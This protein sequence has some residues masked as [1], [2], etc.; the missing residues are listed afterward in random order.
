MGH[1]TNRA[2][3]E[4]GRTGHGIKALATV[5]AAFLVPLIIIVIFV[6]FRLL[7]FMYARIKVDADMDRAA[8]TAAERYIL[9]GTIGDEGSVSSLLDG[10]IRDYPYYSPDDTEM[11]IVH[12]KIEVRASLDTVNGGEGLSR[13]LM[14]N[15]SRI[16]SA[17]SVK[18][19]N[20][21]AIKRIVS[22]ILGMRGG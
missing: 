14:R 6:F 16:E 2:P 7:F 12:G 8:K 4:P 3:D 15:M 11:K 19:W 21:P 22:V 20:C 18:C 13:L 1:K 9:Y 5:E 17:T 10:C